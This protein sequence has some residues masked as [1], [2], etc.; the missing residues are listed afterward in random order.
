MKWNQ[1]YNPA[2]G[3]RIENVLLEDIYIQTGDGEEPSVI[4]GYS[5]E[6]YIQDVTIRRM[7]RDGKQ[8]FSLEDGNIKVGCFVRNVK[9]KGEV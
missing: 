7:F 3:R 6:F 2:P 5:K 8:I 4:S 1:D 9:L